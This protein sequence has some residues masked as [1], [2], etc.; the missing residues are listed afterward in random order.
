MRFR[1]ATQ[2][3]MPSTVSENHTKKKRGGSEPVIIGRKKKLDM[4]QSEKK[5]GMPNDPETFGAQENIN[6]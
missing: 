4:K 6:F 3:S 5:V 1:M 2:D